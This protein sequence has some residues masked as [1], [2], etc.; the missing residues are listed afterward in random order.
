MNF[1]WPKQLLFTAELSARSVARLLKSE[2]QKKVDAIE[3]HAFAET[4]IIDEQF[5]QESTAITSE[6]QSIEASKSEAQTK[7]KSES[8]A[9]L[10][11]LRLKIEQQSKLYV[12]L[13]TQ[14]ADLTDKRLI[15]NKQD[16]FRRGPKVTA[17]IPLDKEMDYIFFMS[18]ADYV[19]QFPDDDALFNDDMAY[20]DQE[21]I[22]LADAALRGDQMDY[23][24]SPVL[25]ATAF[26]WSPTYCT[27]A[28][29]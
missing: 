24:Q 29:A 7:R 11:S 4:M 25:P 17:S 10:A 27:V 15:I 5:E 19:A 16:K 2:H 6:M 22:A 9:Q 28:C 13:S 21:G 20:F 14:L 3:N 1:Q 8:D 12:E 18:P 23:E 26:T